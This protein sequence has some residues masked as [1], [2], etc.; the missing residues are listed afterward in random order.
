[1]PFRCMYSTKKHTHKNSKNVSRKSC[2]GGFWSAKL[3]IL[4]WM[5]RIISAE[6][7]LLCEQF[8][9]VFSAFMRIW[10]AI[11]HWVCICSRKVQK[12]NKEF[13][14]RL[15]GTDLVDI[16]FKL[17]SCN[18][19]VIIIPID[20]NVYI[21]TQYFVLFFNVQCALCTYIEHKTLSNCVCGRFFFSI[22]WLPSG[23]FSLC[24]A[25]LLL[26]LFDCNTFWVMFGIQH[27]Q[28]RS[29]SND[30]KWLLEEWNLQWILLLCI[31]SLLL[32]MNG[33]SSPMRSLVYIESHVTLPHMYYACTSNVAAH[34]YIIQYT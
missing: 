8:L 31:Q 3:F 25:K 32:P 13:S 7:L 2:L 20:R 18:V 4:N 26:K 21:C 9:V 34:S 14:V 33:V 28:K 19:S 30:R 10:W 17:Q 15:L 11:H 29:V 5:R 24:G 22:W 6:C 12:K 16:D 27:N 23:N 1:M